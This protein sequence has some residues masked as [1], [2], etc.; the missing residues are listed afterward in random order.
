M[1][2]KNNYIYFIL[3]L[4]SITVTLVILNIFFSI[5]IIYLN[6]SV[7]LCIGSTLFAALYEQK[8]YIDENNKKFILPKTIYF[9]CLIILFVNCMSIVSNEK[10]N[11]LSTFNSFMILFYLFK[12]YI[13]NKKNQKKERE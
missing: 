12:T 9:V 13:L 6:F 3:A 7:A 4:N 1:K 8:R 5:N 2:N 10:I 11:F